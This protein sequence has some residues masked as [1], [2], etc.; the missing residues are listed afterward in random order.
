[1]VR[2]HHVQEVGKIIIY[3]SRNIC[4]SQRAMKTRK[5]L[6]IVIC[7]NNLGIADLLKINDA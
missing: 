3:S 5:N 7:K 6:S 2:T 4:I 1:M